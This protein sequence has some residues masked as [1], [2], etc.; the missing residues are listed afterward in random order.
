MEL[1]H[2]IKELRL[3]KGLSQRQL[4]DGVITRNMLSQIENG[5]ARPSMDTL[6]Y[7]AERLGK[8]VSFFLEENAVTSPNQEVMA[9]VREAYEEKDFAQVVA[10]LKQYQCPDATFDREKDFLLLTAKFQLAEKALKENRIP[11]AKTLLEEMQGM[12]CPYLPEDWNNRC[13]F[14]WARVNGEDGEISQLPDVENVL[15]CKARIAYRQGNS[16]RAMEYLQAM[17]SRESETVR[18]LWAD[19]LLSRGEYSRAAE[20]YHAL[21]NVLGRTVFEKLEQCYRAMEDYKLAYEYAC[22]QKE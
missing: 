8:P 4:C 17:E 15:F 14:L 5:T 1:G 16:L 9:Q 18:L 10:L 21:E 13:R 19:C 7:F 3:E 20:E 2:R 6:S 11:Y 22:K 12:D